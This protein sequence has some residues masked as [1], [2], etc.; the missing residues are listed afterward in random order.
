MPK[1]G[2][3][4]SCPCGS[5]KKYKKCCLLKEEEKENQ[6]EIKVRSTQK[7]FDYIDEKYPQI[8]EKVS[9]LLLGPYL[10]DI[11]KKPDL[12]PPDFLHQLINEY[13]LIDFEDEELDTT[14]LK[15]YLKEQGPNLSPDEL[16][17]LNALVNTFKTLYEVLEIKEDREVLLQDY[18]SKQKFLVKEKLGTKNFV[19]WDLIFARI[20]KINNFYYLTGPVVGFPREA[21][22]QLNELK[23]IYKK[24][25]KLYKNNQ[26]MWLFDFRHLMTPLIF[27]QLIDYYINFKL[28]IINKEGDLFTFCQAKS[29]I[30]NYD[31]IKRYL[32]ENFELASDEPKEKV[33]SWLDKNN[34]VI[35][36][37]YLR[38]NELIIETNSEER[39]K[40]IKRNYIKKLLSWTKNWQY[41]IKDIDATLAEHKDE[42]VSSSQDE[43]SLEIA[44]QIAKDFLKKH[45]K[46]WLDMPIPMLDNLTPREAA[47]QKTAKGK[48]V[49]LLKLMENRRER[50][51]REDS[52]LN[53]EWVD[54]EKIKKELGVEY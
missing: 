50:G 4:D 30:T 24:E 46:K 27:Q 36:S 33:Y 29:Q 18:F 28:T 37:F 12:I 53:P 3:N 44:D 17:Y 8:I 15:I 40:R 7:A 25:K 14:L 1:I 43:V 10:E 26:E 34:S 2:R 11:K 39:L 51:A 22:F 31:E 42:E 20:E 9:L 23:K 45:Y 19:K 52:Q 35:A 41:T 32:S 21:D 13:M 47:K 5:G 38:R 16:K 49:E 54:I 6:Q 48:L